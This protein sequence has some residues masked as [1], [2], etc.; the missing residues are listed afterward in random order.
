MSAWQAGAVRYVVDLTAQVVT[1]YGA[2]EEH[3]E[4][5]HPSVDVPEIDFE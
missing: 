5:S 2:Q 4:E 3:Y 1:H